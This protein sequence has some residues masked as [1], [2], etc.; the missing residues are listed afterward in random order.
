MTRSARRGQ[1]YKAARSTEFVD[2]LPVSGTSKV[3][4]RDLRAAQWEGQ[5]R[6]VK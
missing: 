5:T 3:L 1:G 4:K 6:R 2:A